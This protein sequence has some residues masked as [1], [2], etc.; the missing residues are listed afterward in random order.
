MPLPRSFEASGFTTLDH[1]RKRVKLPSG[2]LLKPLMVG[3]EGPSNSGKSEFYLSVPGYGM[4]CCIDRGIDACIDNPHPPASRNPNWGFSIVAVPPN[5][6]ALQPEYL[7]YFTSIRTQLYNA[8]ANPDCTAIAIDCHSDFWELHKLASFGKIT[9]VL[10]LR[11][12]GPVAEHRA[13]LSKLHDSGKIVIGTNKVKDEYE[14]VINPVTGLAEKEADGSDKRKKTG[15][16]V[17]QGFGDQ[18][19]LWSIQ[20]RHLCKDG[21]IIQAGPFKGKKKPPQ[22]GIRILKCK[23]RPELKGEELWGDQCNFRGLVELVYP[24]VD[25]A[26]WGF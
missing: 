15:G 5:T 1:A 16:Y 13:I 26:E 17:R 20:L 25:P 19:Y 14:T 18:D 10:P 23:V 7:T 2:A 8:C 9:G 12:T 22:W 11:Y 4:A 6:S 21:D 3:T 24:D